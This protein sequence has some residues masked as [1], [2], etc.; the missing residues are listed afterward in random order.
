MIP[1]KTYRIGSWRT[2]D[3]AIDASVRDFESRFG[4]TPNVLLA[5]TVTFNRINMAADKSHVGNAAGE[6]PP[7]HAYVDITGFAGHDYVLGFAVSERVQEKRFALLYDE[8]P[9]GGE[10]WPDEDTEGVSRTAPRAA[11]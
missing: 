2:W 11:E 1:R 10:P 9:D 5:S 8:D 3:Q 4:V 7:A 6:D